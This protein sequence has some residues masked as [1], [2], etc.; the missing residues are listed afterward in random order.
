[1][2]GL[3]IVP[4]TTLENLAANITRMTLTPFDLLTALDCSA[5][6]ASCVLLYHHTLS[7]AYVLWLAPST[8][9]GVF[10]FGVFWESCLTACVVTAIFSCLPLSVACFG[11]CYCRVGRSV[12]VHA[13]R[14]WLAWFGGLV[15]SAGRVWLACFGDS[16]LIAGWRVAL[17]GDAVAV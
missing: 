14:V 4:K 3:E 2:R 11:V 9:L 6:V 13:G 16:V 17:V 7:L 8:L 15:R 1:V 12:C 5:M 10:G